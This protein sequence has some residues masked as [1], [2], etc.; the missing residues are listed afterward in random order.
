MDKSPKS[1]APAS[2]ARFVEPRPESVRLRNAKVRVEL[3]VGRSQRHAFYQGF[4]DEMSASGIFVGTH[5][6]KPIGEQLEFEIQLPGSRTPITG[7]CEVRWLREY[8]EQSDC[9]PGMG[10]RFLD[11]TPGARDRIDAF[12]ADE[13]ALFFDD[14]PS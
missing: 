12:L 9:G 7:T 14:D 4:A 6:K 13:Q 8:A 10:L 5:V 1:T 11:L 3:S 2:T